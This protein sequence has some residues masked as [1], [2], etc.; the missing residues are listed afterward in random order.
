MSLL[1]SA[2]HHHQQAV[3]VEVPQMSQNT[4]QQMAQMHSH[5]LAHS[6]SNSLYNP[7]SINSESFRLLMNKNLALPVE[8]PADLDKK[9]SEHDNI[10][11]KPIDSS[12]GIHHTI[13]CFIII[14]I[15][16]YL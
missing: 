4:D 1:P 16:I 6:S 13:V 8:N 11:T 12:L 10:I 14:I 2:S 7:P 15:S 5:H 3:S 9:F